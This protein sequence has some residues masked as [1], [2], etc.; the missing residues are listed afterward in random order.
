MLAL[1]L[2]AIQVEVIDAERVEELVVGAARKAGAATKRMEAVRPRR[3]RESPRR[4]DPPAP[5]LASVI[6]PQSRLYSLDRTST[7]AWSCSKCSFIL[8]DVGA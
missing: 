8:I 2:K 1:A 6:S 4:N 5:G 3:L 7:H